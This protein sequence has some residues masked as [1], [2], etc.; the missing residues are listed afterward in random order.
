[1]GRYFPMF[2][3]ISGKEFLVFG[4]GNIAF[5]R[6]RT[7]LDFGAKVTVVAPEICKELRL[8]AEADKSLALEYRRYRPGELRSPEAVLAATDDD[9]ANGLIY[10]EC[11]KKHIKA[12][13]ASDKTKCD[14][15]FPAIV[16]KDN[17]TVGITANGQDH[18][19][20]AE[21]RRRIQALLE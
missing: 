17:L 16:Q 1:M 13:V 11:Q 18:K 20:A 4:G 2:I 21:T 3:D 8:L 10:Q 6:V 14:F 19:K 9:A 7:L 5:R 15:Y 12:N